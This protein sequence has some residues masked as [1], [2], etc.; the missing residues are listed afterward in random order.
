M[1]SITNLQNSEVLEQ[2]GISRREAEVLFW[3]A[4]GKTRNEIAEILKVTL[5][6]VNKHLE[7]I[8][9]KLGVGTATAAVAAA[10]GCLLDDRGVGVSTN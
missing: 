6:T 10:M 9:R 2:L 3:L 7:S 8:Y 4:H 5:S 1:K